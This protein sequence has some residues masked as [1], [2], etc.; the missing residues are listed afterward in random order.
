MVAGWAILFVCNLGAPI[1][2]AQAS[3]DVCS[4]VQL[5]FARG[6]GQAPGAGEYD[7]FRSQVIGRI[8]ETLLTVKSYELGTE[9]HD[10][11]QYPAVNVDHIPNGNAVGAKL[12]AG[13]ANDYGAS[14]EQGVGE[15][16][17]YLSK[18][19]DNCKDIKIILGGYSQG[20]QVIGQALSDMP[21][22][23]R[24]NIVFA[25]LFGDPKLFLPEGYG[26]LPPACRGDGFSAWRR[27]IE[28]CRTYN[29]SLI[30]RAP[31][32]P[33]YAE[34][35]TGLWCNANDYICG[36]SK[37]V[38][39]TVGHGRYAVSGGAIDEAAN[40]AAI[41]LM[42][43][44]PPREQY[45]IIVNQTYPSIKY[46]ID[47]VIVAD[48]DMSDTSRAAEMKAAIGDSLDRA[49]QLGGRM[50]LTL[51]S[52]GTYS[53]QRDV[54]DT[55][56]GFVAMPQHALA[57]LDTW[58][59]LPLSSGSIWGFYIAT[60]ETIDFLDWG[61]GR[62]KALVLLTER[63]LAGANYV[64]QDLREYIRKRALEIDPVNVYPVVA[65][66]YEAGAAAFA[67]ATG[68]RAY[69]F[70][71]A[72]GSLA[73]ALESVTT[74]L[75]ERPVV[76]FS[77]AEYLAKP[78]ET[79]RF[80]VSR[81]YTYDSS[82]AMYDW[83]FNGDG[84]W[85]RQTS[86]PFTEY[87]YEATYDGLVHARARAV[88][89]MMGT[90]T[91][92]VMVAYDDASTVVAPPS[93][94][95]VTAVEQSDTD[96]VLLSWEREIHS[97]DQLISVN[98]VT[99]GRVTPD[100]RSIT[101]TDLN[102]TQD[103]TIGVRS[104]DS[105][106]AVSEETGFMLAALPA[107]EEPEPEIIPPEEGGA[108]PVSPAPAAPAPGVAHD[109]AHGSSLHAIVVSASTVRLLTGY[110]SVMQDAGDRSEGLPTTPLRLPAG[111]GQEAPVVSGN[112]PDDAV[113]I[114]VVLLMVMITL[115]CVVLVYL[116]YTLFH[117]R[118]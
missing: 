56:Y 91:A 66:Q 80:D 85:D 106:G 68:G 16:H 53:I 55:R 99:I 48:L 40:E 103:V 47:L 31:Y 7:R 116:T 117:P 96:E 89:G 52:N 58:T 25:G 77:N 107:A 98:G 37:H 26:P 24:S 74:E 72:A 111:D 60:A 95:A 33:A 49:A 69:T 17:A 21:E 41:R 23:V 61:S 86:E 59:A 102:R 62:A 54:M 6:S 1:A 65:S 12:S 71:S 90:M 81:T 50:A 22:D 87:I 34:S 19:V 108:T 97:S 93:P 104:I 29:G 78:G 100:V 109:V 79:V 10:G 39:D 44:L 36:S 11:Y 28:E 4:D 45:A 15:L 42:A 67:D 114:W 63:D 51:H 113:S 75:I 83:D 5:V 43:A 82:I 101:V 73:G 30:A 57:R 3:D 18:R 84:I 27:G 8:D 32:L 70:D 46:G 2:E 115:A 64:E 76:I 9:P 94:T 35:F 38:W 110:G 112:Q 118:D 105:N 88:N 92:E 14:V 13:M 20:A